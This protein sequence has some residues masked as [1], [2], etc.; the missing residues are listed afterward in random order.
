LASIDAVLQALEPCAD[1]ALAPPGPME[2]VSQA[3]DSAVGT[4]VVSLG[5]TRRTS[6]GAT[7]TADDD[8][9]YRDTAASRELAETPVKLPGDDDAEA[10]EKDAPL[11]QDGPS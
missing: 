8:L 11:S 9:M 4:A 5:T 10:D 1:G 7:V 3:A 6:R 2:K